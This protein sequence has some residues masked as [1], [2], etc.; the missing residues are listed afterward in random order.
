MLPVTLQ[1][2]AES[3]LDPEIV[4]ESLPD[5]EIVAELLPDLEIVAESMQGSRMERG[6]FEMAH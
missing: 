2:H 5:P 6:E 3:L 1:S 4:V